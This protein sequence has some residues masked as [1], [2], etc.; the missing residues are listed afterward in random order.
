S[1]GSGGSIT[2]ASS[3]RLGILPRSSMRR[4]T[5]AGRQLSRNRCHSSK[6]V[7][8]KIGALHYYFSDM[9][10]SMTGPGRRDFDARPP[11]SYAEA[12]EWARADLEFVRREM[13]VDPSRF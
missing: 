12:E 3:S 5:G 13:N 10:E 4:P 7:S 9:Y 2:T 11:R 1:T 8:E 6:Q